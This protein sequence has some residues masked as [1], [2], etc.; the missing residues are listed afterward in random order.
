MTRYMLTQYPNKN[1]GHQR[2]GK[3]GDRNNKKGY[4]PKSEDKDNATGT[5]GTTG[6][7]VGDVTTPKD[8]TA[9]SSKASIGDH[10][11]ESTEHSFRPTRSVENLLEAH[12]ID[13]DIYG[14]T[15]PCDM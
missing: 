12:P 4:D 1:S 7:H 3:K 9:P 13:D 5:T 8:S 15:N 11:L 2:E 14:D 6:A 10:V